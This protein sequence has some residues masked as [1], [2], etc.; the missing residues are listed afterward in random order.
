MTYTTIRMLMK[1]SHSDADQVRD[2][3]VLAQAADEIGD[4]LP[5]RQA[6]DMYFATNTDLYSTNLAKKACQPCP[7]KNMCAEYALKHNEQDGVWGG[8]GVSERKRMRRARR[9]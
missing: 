5:C 4:N 2:W 7:I 6:P 3:M 8:L 9:L 1:I